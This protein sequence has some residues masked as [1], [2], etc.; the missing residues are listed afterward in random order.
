MASR[1][2]WQ[3]FKKALR[4]ANRDLVF[5]LDVPGD[6]STLGRMV[7]LLSPGNPDCIEGTPFIEVMAIASPAFFRG[8]CPAQD[9]V[10]VLR[11]KKLW[12][13][14]YKN[15]FKQLLKKRDPISGNMVVRD[16]KALKAAL[17][18]D[19]FSRENHRKQKSEWIQSLAGEPTEFEK[20][21]QW[22][23]GRSKPIPGNGMPL[24]WKRSKLYSMGGVSNGLEYAR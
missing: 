11:G 24:D 22:L 7:Y 20:K 4:A 9:G 14:G 5:R 12:F 19:T 2:S 8:G 23:K 15:F 6:G 13:R 17:P 1:L 18:L 16:A 3:D 10:E 21:R